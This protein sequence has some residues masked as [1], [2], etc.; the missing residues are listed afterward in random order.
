MGQEVASRSY[1]PSNIS[2]LSQPLDIP[3]EIPTVCISTRVSETRT[4]TDKTR[5]GQGTGNSAGG[6][7]AR[8]QR[9]TINSP[10]RRPR[11]RQ[12]RS[13]ARS[14]LEIEC[15]K[16]NSRNALR[17]WGP[18]QHFLKRNHISI[19]VRQ[20][21]DLLAQT[22]NPSIYVPRDKTH[23]LDARSDVRIWQAQIRCR[24]DQRT[25]EDPQ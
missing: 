14:K 4:H 18:S 21:L 23:E 1:N 17:R 9:D 19:A 11:T 13:G 16:P 10:Y 20:I 15:A 6:K 12:A 22:L 2:T 3:G 24:L 8:G 7:Q 5:S 25:L